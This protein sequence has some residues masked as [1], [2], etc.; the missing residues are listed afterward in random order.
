MNE[1]QART[2]EQVRQVRHVL[3]S[4]RALEFRC[5]DDDAQRY[6][7]IAKVLQRLAYLGLKHAERGT[8]LANVPR[9]S[10][11]SRA[12]V[13]RWV[14]GKPL[15]KNYQAPGHASARR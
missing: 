12:Q 14:G 8:V 15:T 4:T 3:E 6:A 13:A 1:S 5:E 2:L 10:G 9:L 7:W 11:Y